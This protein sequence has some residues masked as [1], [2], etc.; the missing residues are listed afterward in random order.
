MSGVTVKR[1]GAD[2]PQTTAAAPPVVWLARLGGLFLILQLYI[3]GRWIFSDFFVAT[4]T[5]PDALPASQLFWIR[6]WEVFSIVGSL[7]LVAWIVR[8]TLRDREF[9]NLGVLGS[10][11]IWASIVFAPCLHSSACSRWPAY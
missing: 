11:S 1:A 8:K 10:I 2:T 9:P 4:P 6:S 5:G 3:Y 7:L